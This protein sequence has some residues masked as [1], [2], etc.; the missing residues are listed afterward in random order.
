MIPA[1]SV[2]AVI[3]AVEGAPVSLASLLTVVPVEAAFDIS[4]TTAPA[5]TSRPVEGAATPRPIAVSLG[6]PV[7]VGS[8]APFPINT[9]FKAPAAVATIALVP[10][11]TMTP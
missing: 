11:P 1:V 2:V 3:T 7:K 6:E 9:V 4:L 10:S 5:P 8:A